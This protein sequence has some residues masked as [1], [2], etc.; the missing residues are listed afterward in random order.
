[1]VV[2]GVEHRSGVTHAFCDDP[3]PTSAHFAVN[4]LGL[5]LPLAGI[6]LAAFGAHTGR[7]WLIRRGALLVVVPILIAWI[8][9][10]HFD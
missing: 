7:R 8:V 3:A 1:V 9:A 5:V 6:C 2:G 10:A 4:T